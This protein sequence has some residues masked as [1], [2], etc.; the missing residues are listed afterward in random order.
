MPVTTA[1]TIDKRTEPI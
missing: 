1:V